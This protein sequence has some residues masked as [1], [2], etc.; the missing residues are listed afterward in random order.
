MAEETG[1]SRLSSANS[2]FSDVRMPSRSTFNSMSEDERR[3]Y[4]LGYKQ[5][6]KR[7]FS[8]FTNF[9][10]AASM[11]SILLG[12]I[13]LY[14]YQLTIGG[15]VVMIWTWI[16]VGSFTLIL[17]CCLGEICSA[18]PTM[19][20]L[21]FWAFKL[22]GS[23]WGP[24]WSW[25]A[26]WCNLLG[27]IAG[28]AS[29][30]YAGA[31]IIG[32]VIALSRGYGVSSGELICLYGM[33]LVV[34][35]IVNTFAEL[36][37]TALC[38]ISVAWQI[39]GTLVI[40]I[41]MLCMAPS[42][43]TAS[44]VFTEFNNST[45]FQ[46]VGYIALIGALAAGSTFTGYDTAAHVAE[47]TTHSHNSTPWAMILAVVNALVLGFVLIVGMNF[48]IQDISS[49]VVSTDDDGSGPNQAYTI[50]WQQTV[51]DTG[52]IAFLF[53]TLVAIEC[54]NCANLTSAARML[55]SFSRD[56]ALPFS[57][58]WYNID[59]RFG[60]PVRAIWLCLLISFI[61]GLPGLYSSTVLGA[62]F[63]LTATGLYASYVIPIGLRVTVAR[64]T[65]KP[66]EFNLG[67]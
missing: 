34:A 23:E 67:E 51:G 52:A 14:T 61:L 43:Q 25:V 35:G 26:G 29:G 12:I 31:Q 21:Y 11:I 2:D 7:I 6:V 63:S 59:P 57:K 49:L 38:Y 58:V 15:P 50:L 45:G 56:G 9:G 28:V 13:P 60:G 19:G 53:I 16:V 30:G 4:A 65:F 37:L 27:Q 18:Y 39:A 1:N 62:L 42:L 54:S 20:A 55:Y 32:E 36:M 48:C 22:G 64:D 46:S 8:A 66:A 10:L 40:V 47:E 33:M 17:V 3:L 41:S 5:E 24:F 44:F